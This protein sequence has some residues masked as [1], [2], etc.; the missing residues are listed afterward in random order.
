MMK[1]M[2]FRRTLEFYLVGMNGLDFM[3]IFQLSSTSKALRKV[4]RSL[5]EIHSKRPATQKWLV[6]VVGF[7]PEMKL[8][9]I[10][11]SNFGLDMMHQLLDY[12]HI[13]LLRIRNLSLSAPAPMEIVTTVRISKPVPVAVIDTP[14]FVNSRWSHIRSLEISGCSCAGEFIEEIVSGCQNILKLSLS[15]NL[16]L[17]ENHITG[18]TSDLKFLETLELAQCLRIEH[19]IFS[20]HLRRSLKSLKVT[21]CPCFKNVWIDQTYLSD[22]CFHSLAFCD[23]SSS[24]VNAA[25]LNRIVSNSP[26][27]T[28]LIVSGCRGL[29][30]RISITSQSLSYIDISSS[31][32]IVELF[33]EC[34]KLNYLD[35]HTNLK[36]NKL[37][38][39]SR[40]LQKLDLAMLTVLSTLELNCI[41]IYDINLHGCRKLF[42]GKVSLLSPFGKSFPIKYYNHEYF[43]EISTNSCDMKHLHFGCKR[44]INSTESTP[45]STEMMQ[46]NS[47]KIRSSQFFR[48]SSSI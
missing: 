42:N 16:G 34:P 32:N 15:L 36:L 10:N 37:V 26:Q 7:F 13:S 41:S 27:L 46:S 47:F 31:C 5:S 33:V 1:V 24:S 18:M 23:F 8:L 9:S 11:A 22:R 28:K 38:I 4:M 6:N 17:M 20:P 19:L 43:V 21:Q 44:S 40:A 45:V 29:V 35:A 25:S 12:S 14:R 39:G 3:D 30:G 48:R 2:S